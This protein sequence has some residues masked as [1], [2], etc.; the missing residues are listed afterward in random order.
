MA[1]WSIQSITWSF[2][3]CKSLVIFELPSSSWPTVGRLVVFQITDIQ[4]QH[5]SRES[6]L[7]GNSFKS[8][9]HPIDAGPPADAIRDALQK[10]SF[11]FFLF[12]NIWNFVMSLHCFL[13]QG[14][15]S[16]SKTSSPTEEATACASTYALCSCNQILFFG[17]ES[18]SVYYHHLYWFSGLHPFFWSVAFSSFR[19]ICWK[20]AFFKKFARQRCR[21]L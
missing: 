17:H 5:Q 9:V 13:H 2:N 8:G 18:R 11:P 15:M 4:K 6:F 16:M 19:E 21:G 7:L 1:F 20:L 12:I 14:F 3:L 10:F